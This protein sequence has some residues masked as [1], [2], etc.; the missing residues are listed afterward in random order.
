MEEIA[1]KRVEEEHK[2]GEERMQTALVKQRQYCEAEKCNAVRKARDEEQAEAM[3]VMTEL[4]KKHEGN[5]ARVKWEDN[6]MKQV[7]LSEKWLFM[8]TL[9]DFVFWL[10]F[11]LHV[12]LYSACFDLFLLFCSPLIL[13]L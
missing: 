6:Q 7:E 3:Q 10:L 12:L 2:E 9:F 5:I 4:I 1:A 11:H 8:N 13:C